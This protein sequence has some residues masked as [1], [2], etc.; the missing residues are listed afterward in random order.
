[1]GAVDLRLLWWNVSWLHAG[2]TDRQIDAV[3]ALPLPPDVVA[4]TETKA[5][6]AK[7]WQRRLRAE[8]YK[9]L[10]SP[11]GLAPGQIRVL[12]ASRLPL[13]A[14]PRRRFLGVRPNAL[15]SGA[16]QVG[17]REVHVHAV[18]IPNGSGNGW[19]K[20]EHLEAVRH[21]TRLPHRCPQVLCGDFN[22]PQREIDGRVVTW[23]QTWAGNPCRPRR[24]YTK[25]PY[26]EERPWDPL[27]WDKGERAVLEGVPNECDMPD[28]FRRR[29]PEAAEVTW[30]P[31]NGNENR[32]RRF[33]RMYASSTLEVLE[34]R[35]IHEWRREQLSDHSALEALLR[36]P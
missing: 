6:S 4:L 16:V 23:G 32:G 5:G 15:R 21:G 13:R 1:M 19:V 10:R 7:S 26:S 35:H 3:L 14:L 34:C 36:V 24:P 31:R 29:H 33:D 22:T 20:I 11:P 2:Q 28:V 25:P 27:L 8:G 18:H 17:D 9:F 12:L 30:V